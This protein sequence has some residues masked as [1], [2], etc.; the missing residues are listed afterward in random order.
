[1]IDPK[2]K[3]AGSDT[4]G[5]VLDNYFSTVKGLRPRTIASYRAAIEGHLKIWKNRPLSSISRDMVER[6]LVEIANEVAARERAEAKSD[7]ARWE[8]RAKAAERRGWGDAAA[9]H[10]QRATLAKQ[11]ETNNGEV[12]A[13]NAIKVLRALWNHAAGKNPEIG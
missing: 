11:R 2:L 6:R 1:G 10:R 12:A 9:N 13:N 3:K 4:L 5:A 8:E 7:A